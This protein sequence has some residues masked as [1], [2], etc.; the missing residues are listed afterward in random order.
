MKKELRR[1]LLLSSLL[2]VGCANKNNDDIYNKELN[3]P[4]IE[5]E[6][7]TAKSRLLLK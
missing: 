2:F 7:N 5:K 6:V 1:L 3:K 4:V